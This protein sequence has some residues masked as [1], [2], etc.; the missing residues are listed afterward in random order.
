MPGT[1]R[2]LYGQ[3]QYKASADG[4]VNPVMANMPLGNNG[5]NG[6]MP[7]KDLATGNA[8]GMAMNPDASGMAGASGVNGMP[9]NNMNG[10]PMNGLILDM[11]MAMGSDLG[12]EGSNSNNMKMNPLMGS[13]NGGNNGLGNVNMGMGGMPGT[14]G[15]GSGMAL[16]A[17]PDNNDLLFGTPL[18]MSF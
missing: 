11:A 14:M 3:A 15:G 18:A 4:G 1:D 10:A 8:N 16:G 17:D 12:M 2:A 13:V 9:M 5:M 6:M 7:G